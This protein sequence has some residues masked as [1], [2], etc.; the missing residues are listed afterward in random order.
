MIIIFELEI[1][2]KS[3]HTINVKC[4]GWSF[5]TDKDSGEFTGYNLQGLI[6]PSKFEVVPSQIV[7]YIQK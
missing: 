1:Y 2:L 3:G 4:E 6:T 7:G 5:D